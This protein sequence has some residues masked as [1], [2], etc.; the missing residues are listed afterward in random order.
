MSY[1]IRSACTGCTLCA[2]TCPVEAISGERRQQ[3]QIDPVYC[4]ECGACGLVCAFHAVFTPDGREAEHK[5]R[6]TWLKPHWKIEDCVYCGICVE[7]CPTGSIGLWRNRSQ[8]PTETY[9]PQAPYL[10]EPKTC[11][12]CGFCMRDCPANCISMG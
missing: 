12:A 9:P 6:E 3:H 4:I 10:A 7:I 2:R 1:T 5:R 11:I 8:A